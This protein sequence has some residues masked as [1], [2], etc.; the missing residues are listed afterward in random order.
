MLNQKQQE[1]L[2]Y[3][4]ARIDSREKEIHEAFASIFL[5]GFLAGALF[6]YMSL[7]P[8][9]IGFFLCIVFICVGLRPN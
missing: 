8:V 2:S 1:F 3:I 4:N 5:I 7:L 6:T 9:T